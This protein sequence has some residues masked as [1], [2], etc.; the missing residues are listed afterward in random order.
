MTKSI[1]TI[2]KKTVNIIPTFFAVCMITIL[3][4]A[5]GG[6]QANANANGEISGKQAQKLLK[7]EGAIIVDVRSKAEYD[8]RHVKG[9]FLIP[10]D[11]I[12][13]AAP[14]MLPDKNSTV[15][16]YCRTGR[17]TKLAANALLNLGYKNV[18]DMGGIGK[19]KGEFG[20]QGALPK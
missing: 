17:R 11:I 19:W 4:A 6:G 15:I 8:E 10:H 1:R 5:C 12:Q 7:K 18:Y 20:S 16:L 3:I 14:R 9:A 13:T 2:I